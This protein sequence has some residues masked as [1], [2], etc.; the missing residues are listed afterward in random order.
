MKLIL[1]LMNIIYKRTIIK[2]LKNKLEIITHK[3]QD[4]NYQD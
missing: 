1:K 3:Y 2:K 4:S